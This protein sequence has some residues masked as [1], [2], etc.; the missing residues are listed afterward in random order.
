MGDQRDA[1]SKD[2]PWSATASV[3]SALVERIPKGLLPALALVLLIA[4]A[5]ITVIAI[6]T[7]SGPFGLVSVVAIGLF[8]AVL[9]LQPQVRSRWAGAK[10]TSVRTLLA[11]QE[12]KSGNPWDCVNAL[13]IEDEHKIQVL[14]SQAL[15]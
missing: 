9:M 7:K 8:I 14:M 11:D 12:K 3:A 6:Q 5:A 15:D 13:P 4:A 1:G 10:G 2:G